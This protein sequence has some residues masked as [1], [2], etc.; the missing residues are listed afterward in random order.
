MSAEK[1]A[2]LLADFDRPETTKGSAR[3]VPFDHA[4]HFGAK[5]Q[6]KPMPVPA[7]PPPEEDLYQRG[8]SDGYD[9]AFLEHEQKLKDEKA[10]WA[11][12]LDEAQKEA[13][14]SELNETATRIANDIQEIGNQLEANIAGVIAR[15]M[16]PLI[17]SVVQR[18]AVATFVE[19]LSSVA[20]DSRRPLLRVT[21]PSE[22]IELVRSKLG[23]RSIAIE[24]RAE[25]VAEVSI[26]VDQVVLET[27][28]KVWADRLKFAVLA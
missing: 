6:P 21:G 4:L 10:N 1:V 11:A 18:Q 28:V 24:L 2:R 12:Q 23:V 17:S 13:Q 3:I 7:A 22:L 20:T 14:K 27:Q 16:E 25:S 19:R 9:A 26:V 5:A 8:V 15:I